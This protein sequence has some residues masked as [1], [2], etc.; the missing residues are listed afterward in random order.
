MP[1]EDLA[2]GKPGNAKGK[3]L[4]RSKKPKEEH[5]S[6]REMFSYVQPHWVAL[7]AGGLLTLVASG[8][9]LVLPL[10]VR[11][12]IVDL[13]EHRAVTRVIVLMC[14][15]IVVTAALGSYGNYVLRRTAEWVALDTRKNLVSRILRLT[16]GS[17][18]RSEPGDLMSRVTTDTTLLRN[19]VASSFV[20]ASVGTLT[21]LATLAFMGWVDPLLL[22]VAWGA[23]M[24]SGL[25]VVVIVTRVES[26]TKRAQDAVGSMGAALERALGAFRTVKASGAEGRETEGLVKDAVASWRASLSA[27]KWEATIFSIAQLAMQAAFLAALAVGGWQVASGKISIG[28]LVAF[29]LYVFFLTS[30]IVSVVMAITEY[31][32]GAAAVLRIRAVGNL[33]AEPV[34]A[35]EPAKD[36]GGPASVE[37][38]QVHFSY[39]PELADANHGVSFAIPP[40]GMTAFVGPSGAGKTTLFSLIERFY[41]PDSGQVLINGVDT[42]EWP[43]GTLRAAIGYVEQDSPV[44]SGTLRENLLFGAPQASEEELRDAL[45]ISR[46]TGLVA[47]LPEGLETHTGHRGVRLSGGERQRVAIARALLRH[48]RLLLLDE[49]TSQLDAIN[50]AALRETVAELAKLT[51]VLV[52]AHRLSTVTLADRIIVMDVGQVQAIGTHLELVSGNPLYAELAATQFLAVGA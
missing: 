12:L 11:Q 38:D 15:L 6:L 19:A 30:P 18:D 33:T 45:R 9:S 26:T 24:A 31:E 43:L 3:G 13:S 25:V 29:L 36:P 5:A 40:G 1:D 14:V 21:V 35:A 7:V 32:V 46:L 49:A 4:F 39:R 41:D 10:V 34:Q 51:T 42:R 28:T 2:E 37:F 50:E 23:L 47:R 22:A 48:P 52:V 17:L 8:T 44:L 16:V 27:A 20:G